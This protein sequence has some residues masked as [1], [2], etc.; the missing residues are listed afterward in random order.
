MLPGR[1]TWYPL[2]GLLVIAMVPG[3]D[4]AKQTSSSLKQDDD[5][6]A[7]SFV[8]SFIQLILLFV[9]LFELLFC[10][11]LHSRVWGS[12]TGIYF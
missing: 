4:G 1:G 3:A 7:R 5:L 6:F 11:T 8:R 12:S 10:G 9:Y 2:L